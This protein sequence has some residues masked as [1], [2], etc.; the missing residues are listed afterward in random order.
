MFSQSKLPA[1]DKM[2]LEAAKSEMLRISPTKPLGYLEKGIYQG[3]IISPRC[4]GYVPIELITA[5][6]AKED[7]FIISNKNDG[8]KEVKW[9]NIKNPKI[10]LLDKNDVSAGNK[11]LF[12]HASALKELLLLNQDIVL[13]MLNEEKIF[14]ENINEEAVIAFVKLIG[15]HDF[16]CF[17]KSVGP[18]LKKALVDAAFAD[19]DLFFNNS[20]WANIKLTNGLHESFLEKKLTI[21]FKSKNLEFFS[22]LDWEDIAREY[23]ETKTIMGSR[24]SM[25][26]ITGHISLLSKNNIDY[27][28]KQ[29]ALNS[30]CYYINNQPNRRLSI[31]IRSKN[32]SHELISSVHEFKLK[33]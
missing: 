6:I 13:S 2:K 28:Q 8:Q 32:P 16:S 14:F 17:Q 11:T 30:V 26:L 24:D 23:Q 5:I 31:I 18:N 4:I 9:E 10:I 1:Y 25:R 22:T 27:S 7:I 19:K 29:S 33:K 12:F 15:R 20:C 3:E 21:P